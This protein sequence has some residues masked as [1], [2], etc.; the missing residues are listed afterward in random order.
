[1]FDERGRPVSACVRFLYR[2]DREYLQRWL[3]SG[4]E[5]DVSEEFDFA[6]SRPRRHACTPFVA[7]GHHRDAELAESSFFSKGSQAP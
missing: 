7:S 4:E 6:E 5:S 2:L 3:G 1:E